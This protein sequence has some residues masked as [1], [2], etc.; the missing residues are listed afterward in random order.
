MVH[1][2]YDK[3]DDA[4]YAAATAAINKKVWP[5][6]V[7]THASTAKV[8]PSSTFDARAY[9]AYV[10]VPNASGENPALDHHIGT[11][12]WGRRRAAPSL[13]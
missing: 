9:S 6:D 8:E 7:F 10:C 4:K 12:G 5:I 3:Q 1:I 13:K 11:G 2:H